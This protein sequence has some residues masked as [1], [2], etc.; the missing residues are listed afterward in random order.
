M[1][2]RPATVLVAINQAIV[3]SPPPVAA[4]SKGKSKPLLDGS[5]K[6]V[7]GNT[8]DMDRAPK[9]TAK[10]KPSPLKERKALTAAVDA[11]IV[12]GCGTDAAVG[13]DEAA[14]GEDGEADVVPCLVAAVKKKAKNKGGR[15]SRNLYAGTMPLPPLPP[16]SPDVVDV[17]FQRAVV[18]FE[19]AER[20]AWVHIKA[21]AAQ[22]QAMG[23]AI[24]A[25]AE[26]PG[27]PEVTTITLHIAMRMKEDDGLEPWVDQHLL[28]SL[29][30]LPDVKK[31]N[32]AT[33][34]RQP[35]LEETSF[36]GCAIMSLRQDKA[37]GNNSI[38]IKVFKNMTMH[39]TGPK[40]LSCFCGI[41]EYSRGLTEQF[42]RGE[43][44]VIESFHTDLINTSFN[45]GTHVDLQRLA[46]RL[47]DDANSSLSVRATADVKLK[48]DVHAGVRYRLFI[49]SVESSLWPSVTV[50]E[51]GP[52]L[53]GAKRF[54]VLAEAYDHITR[55][56]LE[57]VRAE[58][59]ATGTGTATGTA[60][61]NAGNDDSAIDGDGDEDK[62]N[63]YQND[64]DDDLDYEEF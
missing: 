26:G 17:A 28:E 15:G 37:A 57:A 22:M 5:V 62:E 43:A 54:D 12:H 23:F 8:V 58:E 35:L 21:R 53:I 42:K 38:S 44:V 50:F 40:T 31:Y 49:Q 33:I 34:G 55:L 52:V 9:E 32:D 41:A 10:N 61:A 51:R 11:L 27:I 45:L 59:A 4:K 46:R 14:N 30:Q 24:A 3:A 25:T 48:T 16:P 64:T 39:I 2:S 19:E 47:L 36:N 7:R 60:T 18:E 13:D 63:A 1:G 6:K 29:L 56:A 20:A